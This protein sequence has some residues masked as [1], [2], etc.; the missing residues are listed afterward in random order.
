[1][2]SP[3][4]IS[5]C[6]T[7]NSLLC[8]DYDDAEKI[9]TLLD[10]ALSSGTPVELSFL[11]VELI[12]SSFLNTAIGKLCLKYPSQKIRSEIVFSDVSDTDRMLI[13]RVIENAEKFYARAKNA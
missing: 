10:Q 7:I 4:K 2:S 13:D 5:V 6:D 12:V 11:S 1:M 9:Y 3:L 8:V